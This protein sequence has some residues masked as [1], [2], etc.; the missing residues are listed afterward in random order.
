MSLPP[1]L[2]A[3]KLAAVFPQF[4]LCDAGLNG[5]LVS[6]LNPLTNAAMQQFVQWLQNNPGAATAAGNVLK[7]PDTPVT[8]AV[9]L[10]SSL[11]A[12][13]LPL[14]TSTSGWTVDQSPFAGV[15]WT[16]Q[17]GVA[18]GP[19]TPQPPDGTWHLTSEAPQGGLVFS[20]IAYA[21]QSSP[22]FTLS[23]VNAQPRHLAAYVQFTKA[24]TPV[25]PANWTSRLPAGVPSA[26]ESGTI[27]YLDVLVPNAAVGAIP[28][29]AT[30]QQITLP[31]AANADAAQLL[32]GGLG[33]QPF[34][35]VPDAAGVI[36]TFVL[37]V[38]VPWVA[39][40]AGARASDVAAWF[41][42]VLA[43]R[44][45]IA[46]VMTSGAF[47]TAGVSGNNALFAALSQNLTGAVLGKP[48][49]S[50]RCSIANEL[51]SPPGASYSWVDQFAP[52]AGWAAQ[53]MQSFLAGPPAPQ[54]WPGRTPRIE[55]DLSSA[56]TLQLDLSAV[57]D[58]ASGIWPYPAKNYAATI[59]YAGGFSQTLTGPVPAPQSSA[60][61]TLG[62]GSV[63]NGPI[64]AAVALS[65]AAGN[66]VAR[67]NL[68]ITP[69]P[70]AGSRI[71][72][73]QVAVVD[74]P[75]TIGSATQYKHVARL[76]YRNGAYLWDANAGQSS[77]LGPDLRAQGP[78]LTSLDC[79]TLQGAQLCL[80]YAW[81]ASNQT[82]PACSG[83]GPL[84]NGYFIQNI[85]TA[86]P[87]AQLKTIACTLVA[88]PLLCY[89][90]EGAGSDTPGRRGYYVDTQG[91]VIYLRPVVFGPGSFDLQATTSV[92]SFPA[93]S[94]LSGICLHPSGYAAAVG[95]NSGTLQIA[96]LL[97]AAVPDS[98]AP[99]AAAYAGS[100]TRAGLLGSPVAVAVTPD[101]I[102]LVLE[103][104]NTRVQAFDV[105]G[106]PVPLFNGQPTFPLA[107]VAQP[108]YRDIAVSP[109]GLIYV[110]GSG[111][112][113][114][115]VGDFFL[116]IY[117]PDGTRLCQTSGVNAAKIAVA[118]N[119]TLYTL[120]FDAL[121]GPG[122]RTEPSLSVWRP[123][124]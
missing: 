119:Q 108:Q 106:N 103:R 13:Q 114:A 78:T 28:V 10:D 98:Q 50:L 113:G 72:S 36:L 5:L 116:D 97:P 26:F 19:E 91:S 29:A 115:S 22:Q 34:S 65:D 38:F 123:D 58:P 69:A 35:A 40:G 8:T 51:G 112:G 111:N 110:L 105:D 96:A 54:Y 122:G 89:A 9:P 71:V 7:P 42:G 121:A 74:A 32:F 61:I 120:N 56:T 43:D 99:P 48:L 101:G 70:P 37:D 64:D 30:P 66:I 44:Q 53:L 4:T 63:R 49:S 41:A 109:A 15:A 55:L 88:E 67:G 124:S 85:G 86:V 84:Q 6:Y 59:A 92:A 60:P 1:G 2:L 62:F 118:P 94:G 11:V 107:A 18:P 73:A 90:P 104:G 39:E 12:A 20:D 76:A 83:G 16:V 46:D 95:I 21:G 47:L 117:R 68:A 82:V 27:K 77:A 25:A 93:G 57:P 79:L 3:R 17:T 87:A 81:G 102:F 45:T 24:G 14:L 80:G 23:L 75:V 31:L 52:A 33:S 100:G